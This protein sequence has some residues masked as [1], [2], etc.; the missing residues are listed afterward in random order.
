MAEE[1]DTDKLTSKV[2]VPPSYTEETDSSQ[3]PSYDSIFN[4]IKAAKKSSSG[5]GD[6]VRNVCLI[7]ANTSKYVL[8]RKYSNLFICCILLT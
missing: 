6:Y 4:E 5:R 8:L 1:K 2:A 7:F 3:V